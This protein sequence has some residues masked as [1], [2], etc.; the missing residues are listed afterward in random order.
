VSLVTFYWTQS[1]GFGQLPMLFNTFKLLSPSLRF[2]YLLSRN[3]KLPGLVFFTKLVLHDILDM[4]LTFKL[5]FRFRFAKVASL[6]PT[7][8]FLFIQLKSHSDVKNPFDIFESCFY[9]KTK[10]F[11]MNSK[12]NSCHQSFYRISRAT[13]SMFCGMARNPSNISQRL[14]VGFVID[15]PSVR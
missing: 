8:I 7:E 13:S 14:L 11:R 2:L 5:F 10:I 4:I 1:L 6:N 9:H 12:Q 3:E 15:L